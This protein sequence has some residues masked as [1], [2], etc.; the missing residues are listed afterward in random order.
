M[1]YY[2]REGHKVLYYFLNVVANWTI[3]LV[4]DIQG[5]PIIHFF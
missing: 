4:F 1:S 5:V 3:V 2:F